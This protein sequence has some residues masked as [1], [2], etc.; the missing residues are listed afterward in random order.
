MA[1]RQKNIKRNNMEMLKL[2]LHENS[3]IMHLK[4]TLKLHDWNIS[5]A[6]KGVLKVIT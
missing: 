3:I 6:F 4:A 5:G 2:G 1:K